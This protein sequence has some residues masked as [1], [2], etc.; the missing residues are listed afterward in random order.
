MKYSKKLSF[1][2]DIKDKEFKKNEKKYLPILVFLI[3]LSC[4]NGSNNPNEGKKELYN[5]S[6]RNIT[7]MYETI[8][9]LENAID[10]KKYRT[11]SEI[12]TKAKELG[13]VKYLKEL[14]KKTL[15]NLEK[16]INYDSLETLNQSWNYF[17]TVQIKRLY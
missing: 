2:I 11:K 15:N 6:Q 13:R 4:K 5:L 10:Q 12:I 16:P 7:E 9:S 8:D 3:A 1:L 17:K 14:R